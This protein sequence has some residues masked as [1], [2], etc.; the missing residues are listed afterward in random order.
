M[1]S[2][3]DSLKGEMIMSDDKKMNPDITDI[4]YG[5]KELKILVIYPL[6]IGDQF[7]VTNMIT[8]IVKNLVENKGTAGD[9][10]FMTAIMNALEKNLSK[11]L[12]LVADISEEESKD[13]VDSLTNIQLMD[14]VET[15]WTVNYEPALKK[16]Q[17]LFER[18]RQ[19]FALKRS[20]PSS[21]S[22]TPS[23]DLKTSIEK[24]I[25]QAE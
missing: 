19:L 10:A 24:P 18:G 5:K 7:K 17:D 22:S 14:I 12:S 11:I 21:S 20:S 8:E 1:T 4:T 25:E 6:S 16:G 13:I 15:I 23:T 2:G 3:K 9:Y